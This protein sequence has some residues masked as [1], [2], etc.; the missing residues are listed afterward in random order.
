MMSKDKSYHATRER[1]DLRPIRSIICDRKECEFYGKE[2]QQGVC[3][4]DNGD[5]VKW[6][7]LEAHEREILA[8]M[9]EMRQNEGDQYVKALES[10]YL[11][12]MMNWQL[13][14]DECIRLRRDLAVARARAGKP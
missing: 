2:A 3:H 4:T 11:S 7:A 9:E 1:I 5:V 14:L 13:T 6:D 10:H 8:A 12:A